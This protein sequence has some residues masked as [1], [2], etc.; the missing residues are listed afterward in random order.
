M[1]GVR[2][3]AFLGMM[4]NGRAVCVG[5]GVCYLLVSLY[6]GWGNERVFRSH[7]P[8]TFSEIPFSHHRETTESQA[9]AEILIDENFISSLRRRM[10][11]NRTAFLHGEKRVYV[12]H[13]HKCGGTTL[14]RFFQS[15]RL[16]VPTVK[17]CNGDSWMQPLVHGTRED[18]ETLYQNVSLDVLFNE[19]EFFSQDV[20]DD[21]FVFITTAR[22]PVPRLI[23]QMLHQYQHLPVDDDGIVRNLSQTLNE[24]MQSSFE[25]LQTLKLAGERPGSSTKDWKKL[26]SLAIE[27]LKLFTFTIPT[28]SLSEGLAYLRTF[29]GL[30]IIMPK[31]KEQW[32]VHGASK[33]LHFLQQHEP[34]LLERI[35]ED[36]YYDHCLHL[37]TLKLWDIQKQVL[38]GKHWPDVV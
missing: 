9:C 36:N 22:D 37:Q 5:L 6:S 16:Q 12:Q 14:C 19:R 21:E 3:S 24:F 31:N 17:N 13:Q 38:K 4:Q 28:E 34:Q 15:S 25:N 30:Q 11:A 18:L 2:C 26:H 23:S 8:R 10:L 33:Q 32:N 29:F 7:K 27:R 35:R 1:K 20:P